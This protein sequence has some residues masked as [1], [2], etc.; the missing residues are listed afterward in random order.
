MTLGTLDHFRHFSLG[1][2]YGKQPLS[3]AKQS[4]VLWARILYLAAG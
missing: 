2:L 1:W 3:G 4:L